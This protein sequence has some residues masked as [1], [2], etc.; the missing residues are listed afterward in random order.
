VPLPGPPATFGKLIAVYC[1]AGERLPS[2]LQRPP[3]DIAS[4]T[5]TAR[6][7]AQAIL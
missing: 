3:P 7:Q 5:D 4:T 1:S 6:A 2:L